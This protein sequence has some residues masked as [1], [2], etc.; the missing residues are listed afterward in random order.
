MHLIAQNIHLISCSNSA[1]RG[2]HGTNS[3]LQYC[4][5]KHHR[6]S[7]F[8]H[9]WKKA[10]RIVCFLGCSRN[11][12]FSGCREQRE[13]RL[14]WPHHAFPVLW[15]PGFTVV[16]PSF[17]HLSITLSN[18]RFSN[19]C[20]TVNVG[21]VKLASDSFCGNMVLKMNIRF[22][23]HLCCSSSLI[24]RNNPSHCTRISFCQC[25]LSPTVPLR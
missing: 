24:F 16:I 11:V 17:T 4:C 10:F 2:S 12:N 21:F 13:G 7:N 19:R 9:C 14:V 6:T 25:W 15:C 22:C 18:Q 20:P 5:P 1:V 3:T 8:F 23:C